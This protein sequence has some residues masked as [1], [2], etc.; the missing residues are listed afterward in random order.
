MKLNR[1]FTLVELLIVIVVIAIL[2]AITIVAYNGIQTRA[3]AST[4]LTTANSA[5]KKI[6]IYNADQAGYP[7]ISTDLTGA[8]ADSMPY[9]LT[10]VTFVAAMGTTA[11]AKPTSVTFYKCG[12]G[13]SAP[14]PTTVA[15]ITTPTGVRIDYYNYSTSSTS[16]LSAGVIAPS[17]VGTY[18]VGCVINN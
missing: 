6:H 16:S 7:V 13:A 3:R 14:A 18:N 12:T 11:P 2:A 1:G 17:I 15:G 10:G 5:I 8:S 9:K 4:A